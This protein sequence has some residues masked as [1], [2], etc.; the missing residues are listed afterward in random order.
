MYGQQN[1]KYCKLLLCHLTLLKSGMSFL[2]VPKTCDVIGELFSTDQFP[3]CST[4]VTKEFVLS[5]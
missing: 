2:S 5:G 4:R 3:S 1:V